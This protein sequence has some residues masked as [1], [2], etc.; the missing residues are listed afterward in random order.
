MKLSI[1]I[2]VYNSSKIIEKLVKNIRFYL[3]KKLRNNFEII[4]VNDCS[5]DSSWPTIKRLAKKYTFIKGIDLKKNIG[6]HGAIFV[7]LK[8]S[9]GDKIVLMDDDL[10]HPPSSI[11]NIYNKLNN[12]DACYTFYIKRKHI[13]WKIL[14][15]KMN[16]LFSSFV[17]DKPYSIYTS[18]FKGF[19]SKVKNKFIKKTPQNIFLD[20]L[21]LRYS[22]NLTSVNIIHQKRF[23]GDSNYTVK[24][25]FNL[26]FDMIENFHFY[27]LRFGTFVGVVA[28]LFIKLFRI[29][30]IEK[31]FTYSIKNKTF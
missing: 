16:N 13:F 8:F 15:S 27:P 25:L 30:K 5:I 12:F 26:W 29:F 23:Q 9:K 6:Q 11:I 14:I 20:G 22:K 1:V 18:S 28:F 17:L 24:K 31:K 4:F 3:N 10:Q 21:I 19:T 7:G 2:P